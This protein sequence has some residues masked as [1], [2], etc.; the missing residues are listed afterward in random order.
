VRVW[1]IEQARQISRFSNHSSYVN[2]LARLSDDRFISGS[3]DFSMII[4]NLS[5]LTADS[6]I[7][8]HPIKLPESLIDG[9]RIIYPSG[10]LVQVWNL[11]TNCVEAEFSGHSHNVFCVACDADFIVSG[12]GDCTVRVWSLR[13]GSQITVF[14]GHHRLVSGIRI[15]GDRVISGSYDTTVR[16]WSIREN[17]TKGVLQ[18]H[19]D[20]VNCVA[21][22]SDGKIAVSGS[23]D[24]TVRIW[25]ADTLQL[26]SI[27]TGHEGRIIKV[28]IT[29][30][31]K[32]VFS[33]SDR[34]FIARVWEIKSGVQV[35]CWRDLEEGEDWLTNYPDMR[36][37]VE[38]F[39]S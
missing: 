28:G 10:K 17:K 3:D 19:T 30:D 26:L 7:T 1:S 34:D 39:I 18:A 9:N 22:T 6:V 29:K 36:A 35:Y 15:Q 12:S 5:T 16:I 13:T 4:W 23:N 14:H 33:G 2:C 11:E 20:Y 25:N 27:L 37:L 8:S 31:N 21:I 32:Y 38:Q 24:E